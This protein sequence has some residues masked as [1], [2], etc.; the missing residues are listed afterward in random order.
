MERHTFF[1]GQTIN[2]SV[3][4][5]LINICSTV[6][7]WIPIGLFAEYINDFKV[8]RE[9]EMSVNS[10]TKFKEK[11]PIP[12]IRMYHRAGVIRPLSYRPGNQNR[13]SKKRSCIM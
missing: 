13:E 3:L 10:Q 9:K 4:Q 8:H 6:S 11:K 2:M 5:K 1:G 7:A 12:C